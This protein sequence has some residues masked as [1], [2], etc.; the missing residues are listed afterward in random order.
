MTSCFGPLPKAINMRGFCPVYLTTTINLQPQ[1]TDHP[2]AEHLWGNHLL[3]LKSMT[4]PCCSLCICNDFFHRCSE[5][6]QCVLGSTLLG[7]LMHLDLNTKANLKPYKLNM[8]AVENYN[9]FF[10]LEQRGRACWGRSWWGF[11]FALIL[12]KRSFIKWVLPL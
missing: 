5:D 2:H 8:H 6:G 10:V 1:H 3:A 11:L 4:A 9:W 7:C 12:H